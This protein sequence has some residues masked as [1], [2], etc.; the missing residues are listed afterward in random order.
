MAGDLVVATRKPTPVSDASSNV[1]RSD[2]TLTVVIPLNVKPRGDRKVM[3]APGVLAVERRQDITLI[4]A[5][6]RAFRWRRM[7]ESGGFATINELAAAEKINSSY[8]S[9]VLGLTL[10][11]PDIVEAILE[12]QQPE[13]VAFPL[14]MRLFPTAW[15]NQPA[16]ASLRSE[17]NP[18][19][20]DCISCR[21]DGLRAS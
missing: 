16:L 1:S 4:K 12:G 9:C 11:A 21:C 14:L 15:R 6:A 17:R 3:V 8:V 13:G 18:E 5:V 20:A 2:Q 19:A 10:L 7:L